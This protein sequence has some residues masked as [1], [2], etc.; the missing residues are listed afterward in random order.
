MNDGVYLA[1]NNKITK[2]EYDD[3]TAYISEFFKDK[4]TLYEPAFDLA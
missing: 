3:F 1:L 2:S 4:I